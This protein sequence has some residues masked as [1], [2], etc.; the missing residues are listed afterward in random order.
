MEL[1]IGLG[2]ILV[3]VL[4]LAATFYFGFEARRQRTAR[5]KAVIGTTAAIHRAHGLLVGLK[6]AEVNEK[7]ST[8]IGDGLE[9]LR[10]A[11]QIL[12]EL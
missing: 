9:G 1:A 5:E 11:K 2:G 10:Q 7:I 8:A 6:A 3:G 12:E 4:G